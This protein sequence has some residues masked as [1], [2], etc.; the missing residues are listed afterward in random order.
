MVTEK[1]LIGTS[2]EIHQELLWF[3]NFFKKLMGLQPPKHLSLS[4]PLLSQKFTQ[5]FSILKKV[6]NSCEV[7]RSRSKVLPTQFFAYKSLYFTFLVRIWAD[8]ISRVWI[9]EV[10]NSEQTCY[11]VHTLSSHLLPL[12]VQPPFM[13]QNLYKIG[14]ISIE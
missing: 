11:T 13:F 4:V 2:N 9:R 3:S 1:D 8:R 14:F 7:R 10:Q 6:W 5:Q 12:R